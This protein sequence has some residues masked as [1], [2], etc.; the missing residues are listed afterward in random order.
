MIG[1][2]ILSLAIAALGIYFASIYLTT[3]E[4]GSS[5]VLVGICALFIVVALYCLFKTIKSHFTPAPNESLDLELSKSS[6]ESESG[7]I[8]KNNEMIQDYNKTANARDKLKVLEAAAA[9]EEG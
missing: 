7:I 4:E 2:V 6:A 5:P 1:G 8:Q 9:A 3:R